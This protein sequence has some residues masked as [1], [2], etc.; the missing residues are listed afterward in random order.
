MGKDDERGR[1]VGWLDRL[2]RRA[3]LR[4]LQAELVRGRH[5]E[6]EI[7]MQSEVECPACQSRYRVPAELAGRTV[8][9]R[10]C[11]ERFVVTAAASAPAV[12]EAVPAVARED[13]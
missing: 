5:V 9:C 4:D 7:Q 2:S 1:P 10:K 13:T 6:P 8:A 12:Q 3:V 11:G